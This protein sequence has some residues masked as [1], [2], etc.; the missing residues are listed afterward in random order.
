MKTIFF[1]IIP[2]ICLICLFFSCEQNNV[3]TNANDVSYIIFDKDVTTDTTTVSF[4]FYKEGEDPKIA[5]AVNVYGKLQEKDLTFSLGFDPVRT[6]LPESQFELPE[7]C[8]IKAGE[9]KGEVIIT[10]RNYDVLKSNT[11]LLVLKINEEGEVRE[12]ASRYSRAIIAVTDRIFKPDWWADSNNIVEDYYL[13]VYSER[14]YLMLLDELKKDD[15]VFD[16]KDMNVLRKYTIRLKNT[17]KNING[18]KPKEQWLKD[19]NEVIIEVP[20]AG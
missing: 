14:K 1:Y 6:T 15:V 8:I 4:R 19:E 3:L 13:G 9:L 18:D 10:L 7:K 16:G 5:L 20:I 17:L 11:K 12:G 2:T